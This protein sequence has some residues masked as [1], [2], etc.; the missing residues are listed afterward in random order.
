MHDSFMFCVMR[1][2][3]H[4]HRACRVAVHVLPT[5]S[6]DMWVHVLITTASKQTNNNNMTAS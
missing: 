5:L 2:I 4:S 6:H 3:A 1:V